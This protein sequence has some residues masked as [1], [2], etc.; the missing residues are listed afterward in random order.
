MPATPARN[1]ANVRMIGT[2]RPMM[3]V[4]RAVAVVERLRAR[5]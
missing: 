4:T 5:R 2:K 3:I 1:G